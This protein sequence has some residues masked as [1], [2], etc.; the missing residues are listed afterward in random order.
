MTL[1]QEDHRTREALAA[2]DRG[3]IPTP[4]D[5]KVPISKRWNLLSVPTE[6]DV[7][8]WI[9]EGRN[10]GVRTGSISGIVVLDEDPK[11]GGSIA[12]LLHSLGMES[13]PSTPTVITGSGG[14]HYYFRYPKGAKIGNSS[15]ELQSPGIDIRGEG[16]QVV[17]PG[18]IH[19]ETG[20][21]YAWAPTLSPDDVELADLPQPILD[22]LT[23]KRTYADAALE[24]EINRVRAA[25][26]GERN[27]ALNR[28]AF[29]LG[30]LVGGGAL[31]EQAVVTALL[32][33]S[34]LPAR[35]AEATIRSGIDAGKGKPRR[36]P[37][38]VTATDAVLVP[39]AHITDQAEY[40]EIGNDDFAAAVIE[41]IPQ[42][43]IYR[44]GNVPGDVVGTPGSRTFRVATPDHFR[45]TVDRHVR[46]GKWVQKKK[47]DSA[48]LVYQTCTRDLAGL[49][50]AEGE[51]NP[52]IHEIGVLASYPVYT[53]KGRRS[54]PGWNPGDVFYDEP[55][56]LAG[57]QPNAD[58]AR[59]VLEDLVI[60]FP[61]R[62]EA[63]RQNYYGLLLT[64]IVRPMLGG[65]TPLHV[66]GASLPG[67]GKTY[68]A[69]TVL[70]GILYGRS[71]PARQ[72]VGHE[73]EIEKR[74]L[75][76]L[77]CGNTIMH[78]DNLKE[79]IDSPSMA[80]LLT[81]GSFGGRL[82]GHM[83]DIEVVNNLTIVGTG[84][85]IRATGE[86]AR[87]IIPIIL[88]PATDEP[89]MRSDFIYPDLHAH[90]RTVRRT[91]L[92]T[93]LGMVDAWLAAGRPRG[94]VTL[95]SFETW[96]ATVGGI[97][98]MHGFDQWGSNLRAWQRAAD[99]DGEDRRTFEAVWW[100]TF[101]PKNATPTELM[102]LA[103]QAQVFQH[104]LARGGSE[105]AL[106]TSFSQRI[107]SRL[108]NAPIG[109][110]VV[111][112]VPSGSMK[113]YRLER[114]ALFA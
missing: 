7:E 86:I 48:A 77:L 36:P 21:V 15:R 13:L 94:N 60:D 76:M 111:R 57:L 9:R 70:G 20:Q 69:E 89:Q 64:P 72:L 35:E 51:V 92:E 59:E 104:V 99:P 80:S 40:L 19:P 105:R 16:G 53:S 87:R 18:S 31:D 85:N 100:E 52:F 10:I 68:L 3:W 56:E 38:A 27:N 61:F 6:R 55:A 109:E 84:N 95:G 2:L 50:L 108:V 103:N 45:L 22:R 23:K 58:R 8:Q 32:A 12:H 17:Y 46:L 44:R 49:V 62:D 30:Q 102:H 67:T 113:T 43:T 24:N 4:L 106:V 41:G 74:I 114:G 11:N 110:S 90:V 71:I 37:Q 33:A 97:L 91:V 54:Q 82:L 66:I 88:Q 79:F 107:L 39:G 73:E 93:L 5:G 98:Q 14:R 28:A 96:A 47:D 25:S 112:V 78:L 63:D 75:S 34:P 81:A 101:G 83:K 29:S 26:E 65:N 1:P 42:G